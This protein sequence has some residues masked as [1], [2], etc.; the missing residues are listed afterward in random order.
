MFRA[1]IKMKKTLHEKWLKH[2]SDIHLQRIANMKS[3]IDTKTPSHFKHLSQKSKKDQ[4]QEG[5]IQ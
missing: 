2:I 3:Q 4:L 5:T 1:E